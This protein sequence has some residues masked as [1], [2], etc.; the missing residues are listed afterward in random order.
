MLYCGQAAAG[1]RPSTFGYI[2]SDLLTEPRL[3]IEFTS[4]FESPTEISKVR[5]NSTFT[6]FEPQIRISPGIFVENRSR[7]I[8]SSKAK[9]KSSPGTCS[10]FFFL[11]KKSIFRNWNSLLYGRPF[12]K[13]GVAWYTKNVHIEWQ[14]QTIYFQPYTFRFLSYR[15]IL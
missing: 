15:R 12:C 7:N 1:L 9:D 3:H 14:T 6:S 13:A 11:W 5:L 10:W 2:S 8:F 4:V